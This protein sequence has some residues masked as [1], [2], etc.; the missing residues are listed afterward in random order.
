MET[1]TED[2]P[3]A[4]MLDRDIL[5]IMMERA[6]VPDRTI[7]RSMKVIVSRAEVSYLETCPN[8]RRCVCPGVKRLLPRLQKQGIPLGLVTGN[9]TRIGWRKLEQ[10]GIG[11][12]FQFGAFAEVARDRAGLVKHALRHARRNKY[13]GRGS[14]VSLIGD[15]PN[16]VNAARANGIRA[17]AVATGPATYQELLELAPDIL[18]PSLRALD[19][20]M[21]G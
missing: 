20:D 9:L 3:V 5:R 18:L 8:L 14:Q 4:G 13:I 16:D 2:V 11:H 1:T 7:R 21:L 19:L 17:I 6:G 12:Y 10:A 15:H